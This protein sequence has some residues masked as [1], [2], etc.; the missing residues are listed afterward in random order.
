MP[1]AGQI[2]A[3]VCHSRFGQTAGNKEKSHNRVNE[4]YQHKLPEVSE[5]YLQKGEKHFQKG[6][7]D[8]TQR[9]ANKQ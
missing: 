5:P 7:Y 9:G 2:S 3:D 8:T 6:D 4:T 1:I